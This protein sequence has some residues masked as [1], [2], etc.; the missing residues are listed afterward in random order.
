MC[1][2][3]PFEANVRETGR[4]YARRNYLLSTSDVF[5]LLPSWGLSFPEL[6]SLSG[7]SCTSVSSSEVDYIL[8]GNRS[9]ELLAEN[10]NLRDL[11]LEIVTQ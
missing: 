4:V 3:P 2:T 10:E 6:G 7:R 11:L 8:N 5:G 1:I 9:H